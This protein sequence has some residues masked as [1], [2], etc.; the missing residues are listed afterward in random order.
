MNN[1]HAETK[2]KIV[3]F[4]LFTIKNIFILIKKQKDGKDQMGYDRLWRCDR[5]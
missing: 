4:Y 1:G 2:I 5:S 3:A